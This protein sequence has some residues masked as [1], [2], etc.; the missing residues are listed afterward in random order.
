MRVGDDLINSLFALGASPMRK[1]QNPDK[2]IFLQECGL[3][4]VPCV[5]VGMVDSWPALSRWN[6]ENFSNM[7]EEAL[8]TEDG[9]NFSSMSVKDFV[10]RVR[11]DGTAGKLYMK[12]ATFHHNKTMSSEFSTPSL[13]ENWLCDPVLTGQHPRLCSPHYPRWSW[14]YVGPR[15]SSSPLHVDIFHSSAFNVVTK[16]RKLWV[17]FPPEVEEQALLKS[18][19]CY[20]NAF[21]VQSPIPFHKA[22]VT[23]QEEVLNEREGRVTSI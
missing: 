1:L 9:D 2:K 15:G 13:F 18:K 23:L 6:W 14:M 3:L 12:D 17:F 11:V 21:D 16:G 4:N 22:V 10:K 7:D 8:V 20:W 19:D 5:V